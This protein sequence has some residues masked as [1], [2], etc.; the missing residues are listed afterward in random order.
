FDLLHEEGADR[1]GL[2]S[3][4]LHDRLIGR[5][6]RAVGLIKLLEYMQDKGD[7]WFCS[8]ADI[9]SHWRKTHPYQAPA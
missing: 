7:V 6:A 9:A 1:P 5:P 3:I 8:G 2:L 4:G